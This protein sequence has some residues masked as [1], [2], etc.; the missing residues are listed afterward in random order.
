MKKAL[1]IILC[2][3]MCTTF[4]F[5]QDAEAEADA[6]ANSQ[7]GEHSFWINFSAAY[8]PSFATSS[9]TENAAGTS[10]SNL[11]GFY[12]GVEGALGFWYEY[13][14]NTPGNNALTAGNNVKFQEGFEIRGPVDIKGTGKIIYTPIAF[15]NFTGGIEVATGWDLP[16][17]ARGQGIIN[18]TSTPTFSKADYATLPMFMNFYVKPYIEALFQ[19]DVA[20]LISDENSAKDWLHIVLQASYQVNF[21][22]MTGVADGTPWL[23]ENGGD[24]FNGWGYD[25]YI[26]FG[27][28][29]PDKVPVIS[30]VG[31]QL[32]FDGYYY[33]VTG[34]QYTA[35]NPTFVEFCINPTVVLA[36]DKHNNLA[37]QCRIKNARAFATADE[38]F[39]G[40]C[41]GQQ[42]FF[43]RF[44]LSYTYTF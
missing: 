34:G 7:T 28:M 18:R 12:R 32:E 2:V 42:Y 5:A 4:I 9:G 19:F 41:V 44:A 33:D 1:S 3:L 11:N 35:W 43:D 40:T 16:G 13:K 22:A 6:A 27:Y 21:S 10:W 31:V 29:F 15:L 14:L 24:K 26:T 39:T 23:W 37:I 30:L 36:F 8:Y 20:A 17:L 25:S 38:T